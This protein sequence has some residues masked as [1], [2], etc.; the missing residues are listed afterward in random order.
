MGD[1]LQ[2]VSPPPA[3]SRKSSNLPALEVS[4]QQ[5]KAQQGLPNA[6]V[7]YGI[8]ASLLF[9]TSFLMLRS[10]LW[11]VAL[12]VLALGCC[13]VGFAIYLLKHQD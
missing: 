10:G 8:G 9:G 12:V 3:V 1:W 11:F 7:I 4:A 6:T 13:L 2:K 5:S